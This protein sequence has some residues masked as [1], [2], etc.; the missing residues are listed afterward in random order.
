MFIPMGAYLMGMASAEPTNAEKL[1]GL[2]WDL[3]FSAANS[4][5]V[6]FTFFGSVFVLFLSE[7]GLSKSEIGTLLSLLPF[8][9]LLALVVAPTVARIGY[10][11]AALLS[12]GTRT[13]VT[14]PILLTP[15]VSVQFGSRAV[16]LHV[17]VILAAFSV[18]RA[19]G[20]TA[21]LPWVQEFVPDSVRG[22]FSAL[23]NMFS[24]MAAFVAVLV[25]GF[26]VESTAGLT[27][28]IILFGLGVGFGF[29]AVWADTHVP[30][31][32]PQKGSELKGTSHRDMLR[33]TRDGN[34]VRF[35]IGVGL[36]ILVSG[37]LASFLPLY[38]QEEVGISSGRVV[39]LQNGTL[40]G[41]L[42][43]SYF[44]GW[45]ADRYGGKPVMMSG[46]ALRAVMPLLWLLV[47]KYSPVSL[48]IALL[49][50]FAQGVAN[51]GWFIG[52]TRLRFVAVVPAEGKAN[53]QALYLAWIGV[54]GGLGQL[55]GGWM[56]DVTS[57][58][59]GRLLFLS[60]NSYTILFLVGAALAIV[61]AV[62]MRLV[63]A[64]TTMTTGA[65]AAM[66][67]RGN[68]F[69]ALASLIRFHRARGE[70]ATVTMTERLGR[71]E[72]PLTVE[73]LL[74]ALADPRFAVRFEAVV[75]IARRGQDERLTSALV[76][77]LGCSEPALSTVAA[78]ALGRI[79]DE[80]AIPPLRAGLDAEYRSVRAHCARAL[81][82]IGDPDVKPLLI[83]R[84]S[85][86]LDRG[87]R[88]AYSSA[89]GK[90]RAA[91][92]LPALLRYLRMS[93]IGDEMPRKEY[94]LAVARIVG[95]EDPFLGLLRGTEVDPGTSAS[96][97]LAAARR[98]LMDSG[99]RNELLNAVEQCEDALAREDLRQGAES[100]AK[101]LRL[102]P[103]RDIGEP[104][105]TV[106]GECAE[107]LDEF[108][109]ERIEYIVL[110]INTLREASSSHQQAGQDAG[111][112]FL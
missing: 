55:G 41:G 102:V 65:F 104:Y 71:T 94:A 30:G 85:S 112:A 88:L 17:T 12:W 9:G 46:I 15:L 6:Q 54:I 5:F 48:Y 101:A 32:A 29:V 25:A 42:L 59:T 79:G 16:L 78:W 69:L 61:A 58:V 97:A 22:K 80:R 68:P 50:A 18:F 14:A 110:G 90:L 47:P 39:W 108:G 95:A 92:A 84:L 20:M 86:E 74:A 23:R 60:V 75:S 70:R 57:G 8:S 63:R 89:L 33:A 98:G 3:A 82:S 27:G 52:S 81:G 43:F 34:F 11:R 103:R 72:S 37:P 99:Y 109:E 24:Q 64:D 56:L 107:R 66:F 26:I 19:V 77:V 40:L 96:Q 76:D 111:P 44:W 53:Y 106:M 49:V 4:I 28:F 38:M 31:G 93:G 105:S 13:A 45:L 36:V 35:L 67:F 7:L 87:L 1:R 62:V 73:E 51:M 2:P 100:L 21:R 83:R 91:D 10:K